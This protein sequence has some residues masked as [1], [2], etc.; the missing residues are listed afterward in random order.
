MQIVLPDVETRAWFEVCGDEVNGERPRSEITIMLPVGFETGYRNDDLSRQLGN[1]AISDGRGATLDSSTESSGEWR[2]QLAGRLV[3][4]EKP[5][6]LTNETAGEALRA[7]MSGLR[8]RAQIAERPAACIEGKDGRVDRE[9]RAAR[10]ADRRRSAHGLRLS[11]WK[12]G[13]RTA[14]ARPHCR[15]GRRGRI[16]ARTRCN[17]GRRLDL[18]LQYALHHAGSA[19][20]TT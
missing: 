14:R 16:S 18:L 5:F 4:S 9:W 7:F 1:W 6:R 11:P 17:P 20:G 13:R 12:T 3:G 19:S 10:L 2:R 8:G 15:R